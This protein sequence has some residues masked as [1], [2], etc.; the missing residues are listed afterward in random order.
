MALTKQELNKIKVAR[1]HLYSLENRASK[2]EEMAGIIKLRSQDTMKILDDLISENKRIECKCACHKK[3]DKEKGT[4]R[5]CYV[6]QCTWWRG[7]SFAYATPGGFWVGKK[8][9][10]R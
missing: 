7:K 5:K 4:C 1:L 6:I 3:K 10:N 2:I 9:R 8:E